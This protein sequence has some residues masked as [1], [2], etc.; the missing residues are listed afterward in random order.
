MT[1]VFNS[2]L[3]EELDRYINAEE[4]LAANVGSNLN[5]TKKVYNVASNSNEFYTQLLN[6]GNV[7]VHEQMLTALEDAQMYNQS[8]LDRG[9]MPTAEDFYAAGFDDAIINEGGF[10]NVE[11]KS[12]RTQ[13]LTEEEQ[14]LGIDMGF[15]IVSP[16][17]QP[18]FEGSIK[19]IIK[20]LVS[21]GI[22][23]PAKALENLDTPEDSKFDLSGGIGFQ[24][25][26]PETGEFDPAIKILSGNERD[27]INQ[28]IKS[29]E[30]PYAVNLESLT[31]VDEASGGGAKV[32]GSFSKFIGAYAGLG[33]FFRLGKSRTMQGFTGGAAADFL[34]FE[35]NEGRLSDIIYD[36]G[37][38]FGVEIPQ[39][40]IVDF[41]QT[42]P[43]DPDYV[44]RFKNALEGGVIGVIAEPILMGLGKTFRMLKDGDITQKQVLPFVKAARENMRT[45]FAQ[46]VEN[47]NNRIADEGNTL[48]S[49]PI[50]PGI[51]R[52][53]AAVGR[54]LERT[55]KQ[56]IRSEGGLPI[57]QEKGDN[58]FRLHNQRL[59]A[60]REKGVNYPGAPKNPHTVIKA[61]ENSDLPDVVVGNIEPQDWQNRIEAA[62]SKEE[63]DRAASWYK[64]VFGE[65]QNQADGDPEEI[66]RLTD[67][68]FAGQQNSSPQQ[69]LNDV[70]F[71][72]EQIKRGVPKEQLKGKGLPSANKI[73]IDI[74]TQSEITGGAGQKIADFLDS[75]Y[76]KNVRS[77]M[78]NNAEGG[79]P[80]VVDIH[81]GRDTGLVDQIFINHLNRLGY[82]VPDNL[83]IDHG[84][85]GIKGAMYESRALFGQQLTDHL[86]G[87]NWMGR[88]DW[89]PAEIQAIGWM[90]LSNMYGGSNVGGDIIDAFKKTTRNISMEVDPGAGSPFAV[91]FGD[92]YSA[93]PIDAQRDINNQVTS[94]AIETVNNQLGITLGNV[95]HGTGGW[96]LF[97]NPSTVQQAI[98]SKDIAIEA[99]ARLGYMLQQTEVWVNAPKSMTKNPKHFS[100]DIVENAGENLRNSD[101]LTELFNRIIAD[102]PNGLFRGYQPIIVDGKPGIRIL[103]TDQAV[104]ESPLT[105]AKAIEYIQDFANNKLSQITDDLQFDA[106]VDIMEADL[107][108]LGNNWTKDKNGG[109]YK[110]YFSGQSG[111]NASSK[112]SNSTVLDNDGKELEQF[113]QGLI[114]RAKSGNAR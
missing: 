80:F 68:W 9:I 31:Q 59:V 46:Q 100:I 86:N 103:I 96:E 22:V 45:T 21:G 44:G 91:K 16:V 51:D 77:I 30:L 76:G 73:V 34:A 29:G 54:T 83:V 8:L 60:M 4:A 75:G 67:A 40:V 107:T 71:V 24:I 111:K 58:N 92:D 26:N 64:I 35:G 5:N 6:G 23:N 101:K 19:E 108:M 27:A 112:N 57:V 69:T 72:Y 2:T 90:Q 98:A 33:K 47:A 84:G 52:L 3:D 79:S 110:S 53:L 105:K 39:N 65:F 66:A 37:E 106:E 99:A 56:G 81:T 93:L 97:Q 32:L 13:P 62:M 18:I 48:F 104:K 25:F 49:N 28:K 41:M 114:E 12:G 55:Q 85:G 74:L 38:A 14:Q 78:G 63:I 17:D 113:F 43:T 42:D 89:E 82:N 87:Q 11:E 36:L 88:S 102:E 50:Q 95:V 7:K 20:G 61:P 94:K 70:L 10:I 15:D 1:Y 109:G